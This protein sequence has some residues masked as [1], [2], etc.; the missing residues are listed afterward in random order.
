MR[1]FLPIAAW[2]AAAP[3]LAPQALAQE[4]AQEQARYAQCLERTGAAQTGDMAVEAYEAALAW[5]SAGGGAPA[6]HCTAIA[7]LRLGHEEEAAMRLEALTGQSLFA[8][9]EQTAELLRQAASAWLLAGELAR[10]EAAAGRALE[11]APD[12]DLAV[13]R[14][15]VRLEAENYAGAEADL[16]DALAR[17]AGDSGTLA[18]RALARMAQGDLTAALRDAEAA[19]EADPQNVEARLTLGDVREAIRTAGAPA[20]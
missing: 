9:P 12:A 3:F 4:Q 5:E 8:A 18:L 6:E 14:A 16:T 1:T 15:R 17:R 2:L 20:R 13:L 19:V 7:L 10:A 11:A